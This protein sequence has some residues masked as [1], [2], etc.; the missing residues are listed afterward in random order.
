[1]RPI[2]TNIV[3]QH[4]PCSLWP[5]HVRRF[6]TLASP[7][8]GRTNRDAVWRGQT[9]V[10]PVNHVGVG[11]LKKI[12]YAAAAAICGLSLRANCYSVT[13]ETI[14]GHALTG[15]PYRNV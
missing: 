8:N 7:A 1:M 10:G 12:Q 5:T 4:G 15:E 13:T 9:R 2:A 14:R 6:N 11:E 3:T